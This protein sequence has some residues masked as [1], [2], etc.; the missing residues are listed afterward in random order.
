VVG[1]LGA[2]ASYFRYC[3]KKRPSGSSTRPTTV[4]VYKADTLYINTA[5]SVNYNTAAVQQQQ[6]QEEEEYAAPFSSCCSSPS[7]DSSC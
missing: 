3:W 2:A 1:I 4:T 6:Q 5:P 7:I